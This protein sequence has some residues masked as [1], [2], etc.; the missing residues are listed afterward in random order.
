MAIRDRTCSQL[1]SDER[2]R[3]VPPLDVVHVSNELQRMGDQ[4]RCPFLGDMS[5]S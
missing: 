1:Q 3:R 2:H 4:N 5:V